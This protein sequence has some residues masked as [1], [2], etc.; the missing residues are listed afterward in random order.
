MFS[1][2]RAHLPPAEVER[3]ERPLDRVARY[4]NPALA[5]R[6]G[7]ASPVAIR[8][9]LVFARRTFSAE[10]NSSGHSVAVAKG[11]RR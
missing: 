4:T 1:R 10:T 2:G 6:G 3:P 8:V 7:G 11:R 5:Y 9:K